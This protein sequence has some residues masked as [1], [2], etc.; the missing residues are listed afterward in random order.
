MNGLSDSLAGAVEHASRCA[1]CG[2]AIGVGDRCIICFL[3]AGLEGEGEA[4]AEVFERMLAEAD[5]PD[6]QW[7]LGNYEI[8]SE[9]GR[10][11]MGAVYLAERAD[12][13]YKKQVAI[14]LIK[15]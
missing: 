3:R 7:R 8:V 11:G 14:K 6:K 5:V 1:L 2:A 4:S 15:R 12:Q 13:Q 9:I 10:G